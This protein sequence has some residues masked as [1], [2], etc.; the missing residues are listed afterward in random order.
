LIHE[1]R[2]GLSVVLSYERRH[3]GSDAP[4]HTF[5]LEKCFARTWAGKGSATCKRTIGS[6]GFSLKTEMKFAVSGA[7][8]SLNKNH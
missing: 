6:L 5:L 2:I 3:I 4:T 1:I 8:A 7:S